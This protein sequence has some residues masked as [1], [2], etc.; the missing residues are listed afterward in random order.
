MN[1]IALHMLL[2]DTAKYVALVI[3]LTFAALLLTQQASIFF[4]LLERSTGP[5][6]NIGQPDLW[7]ADRDAFYVGNPRQLDLDLVNRVRSV[8]GVEWAEPLFLARAVVDLPDGS[9]D[10]V[11]VIGVDRSTMVGRPPAVTEGEVEDLRRPDAIMIQESARDQ[12]ANPKIGDRL[13]LNDRRAVV[14]GFCR[15]HAG[16]QSDAIAYTTFGNAVEFVPLGRDKVAY[17]LVGVRDGVDPMGVRERISSMPRL[18]AMTPGEFRRE[19]VE[20]IIRNTGIGVNFGITV[21]LGVVI[22]LVV[23]AAVFQQ[24]VADNIRHFATLKA[25]GAH[26]AMLIRMILVQA[27]FAGVVGFGIGVGLAGTFSF[28]G[29]EPGAQ[30][31][32]FFP[33]PL[34][35]GSAAAMLIVVSLASTLSM[36]KVFRLEPAVVFH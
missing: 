14:V 24:F 1:R 2:G 30:L 34:L 33:W 32:V 36:W 7:V 19:S 8:P 18:R 17:I 12:L 28:T 20:F 10:D 16:L 22:G 31:D 26:N 5:L 13:I 25:M 4:G 9:F 29:R 21:L 35:V 11:Q 23:S 3:G 6:Q 27:M 15:V